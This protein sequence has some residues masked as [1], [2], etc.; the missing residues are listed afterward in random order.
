MIIK[1][2][3]GK[4]N[5]HCYLID[6]LVIMLIS[7]HG[8]FLFIVRL[9]DP[10]MRNFIINLLLFNREFITNYKEYL[11]KEK[12][13]NE[14]LTEESILNLHEETDNESFF[15]SKIKLGD[16]KKN[17]SVNK[18][19][20]IMKTL[21]TEKINDF[22]KKKYDNKPNKKFTFTPS[23][24]NNN[25][26][27]SGKFEMTVIN[28]SKNNSGLN[29]NGEFNFSQCPFCDNPVIYKLER[30]LCINKCFIT[31]VPEET[32]DKNYTLSN[33][34]EQYKEYYSKHLKCKSDLMTLYVD[35]ESKCAE[36]LCY[37]CEKNYIDFN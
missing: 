25:S 21:S 29:K 10:L 16:Y 17:N 36:F 4:S 33:F 8:T 18:N 20:K 35:K 15:E 28:N 5:I 27:N 24:I 6:Y 37:K 12:R 34:M 9:F 23:L 3:L 31:A 22:E 26:N 7:F 30:V 32:F 1:Y 19:Y 2:I 13:Y 14:S 11:L